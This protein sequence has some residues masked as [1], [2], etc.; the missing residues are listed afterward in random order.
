MVITLKKVQWKEQKKES[1]IISSL[2]NLCEDVDKFNSSYEGLLNS[3]E[4]KK[5]DN[6]GTDT[7]DDLCEDILKNSKGGTMKFV[8]DFLTVD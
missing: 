5:D 6:K 1:I 7:V 8:D 2:D 4:F 3:M